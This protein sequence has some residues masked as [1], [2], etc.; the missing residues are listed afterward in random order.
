MQ[1]VLNRKVRP[2][3]DNVIVKLE[4]PPRERKLE[5]GLILLGEKLRAIDACP[6]I[7]VAVPDKLK[8]YR[9]CCEL[10]G[11]PFDEYADELKVGDKVFLDTDKAGDEIIYG[12]EECRVVRTHEILAVL[13]ED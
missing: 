1:A 9:T 8:S 12:G 3:N 10:C 7:V 13:E 11:R 5:S 2:R 6:A 4:K